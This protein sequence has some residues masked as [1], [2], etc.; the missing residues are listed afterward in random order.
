MSVQLKSKIWPRLVNRA[1][2]ETPTKPGVMHIV[3]G[4]V[5]V[6][7]TCAERLRIEIQIQTVCM[8]EA[9]SEQGRACFCS[10][11]RC[12]HAQSSFFLHIP[13]TFIPL[14][15]IYFLHTLDFFFAWFPLYIQQRVGKTGTFSQHIR[16]FLP[17]KPLFQPI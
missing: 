4:K 6:V 3:S 17:K 2:I 9:R 14:L 5:E 10:T 13:F 1:R 16:K 11:Y 7:R 12:N 8:W 15:I